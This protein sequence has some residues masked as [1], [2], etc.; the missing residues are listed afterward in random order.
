M[1]GKVLPTQPPILLGTSEG[2]GLVNSSETF[3][4]ESEDDFLGWFWCFGFFETV[5]LTFLPVFLKEA[6]EVYWQSLPEEEDFS[7]NWTLGPF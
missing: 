2:G 3:S 1:I 4:T 6:L 5:F 7:E